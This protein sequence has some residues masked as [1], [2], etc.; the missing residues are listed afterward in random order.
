MNVTPIPLPYTSD[1]ATLFGESNSAI[2]AFA[3]EMQIYSVISL[4]VLPAADI[5]IVAVCL[6]HKTSE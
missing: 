5:V 6:P 1:S 4:C 3:C 2:K